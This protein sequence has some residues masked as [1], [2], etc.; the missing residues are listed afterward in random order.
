M[1]C[2]EEQHGFHVCSRIS[3]SAWST[4]GRAKACFA[5]I[6]ARSFLAG[7][8]ISRA[9]A[10]IVLAPVVVAAPSITDAKRI[11]ATDAMTVGQ[12]VFSL[13]KPRVV[14]DSRCEKNVEFLDLVAVAK[15]N[16][17]LPSRT[18]SAISFSA[19]ICE[20]LN[21]AN[22]GNAPSAL[23]AEFHAFM[24]VFSTMAQGRMQAYTANIWRGLDKHSTDFS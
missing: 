18:R 10:V 7:M 19:V 2:T 24:P 9:A 12:A 15:Q 5:P 13:E 8:T 1:R 21:A 20:V 22:S 11:G 4:N 23:N 16:P 6:M 17:V 3:V 14:P